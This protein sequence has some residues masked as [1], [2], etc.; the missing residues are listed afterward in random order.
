MELDK[1]I[2]IS[3]FRSD[4]RAKIYYG[5]L[6]NYF[7]PN[8]RKAY[9]RD[10]EGY[11][12]FLRENF[13]HISE[14]TAEHAHVVAYKDYLVKRVGE[15]TQNYSHVSIN[16]ALACLYAFYEYL[17]DLGKIKVNPVERVRRFKISKEVKTTDL[18]DEQVD[19]LFKVIPRESGSGKLHYAILT[20]LFNTGMRHSEASGLKFENLDYENEFLVLRYRAKGEKEMVTPLNQKTIDAVADY[21]NWCR[22]YDY[23]TNQDDFIFRPTR[24]PL[25]NDLNKQLD[26]KSMSY[27]IKKYAKKIGIKGNV[28]I[29]SARST[30]IGKLLEKG[31]SIDR[32][33][34]FVGHRDIST[35]KAYNKRKIICNDLSAKL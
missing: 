3:E 16:R 27:M 5:F 34:D 11:L 10:L 21:L 29:H 4:E 1:R 15:R 33:A 22:D 32:V 6:Q 30:V 8:T 18:S 9:K 24:N 14:F 17:W 12:I 35:T 2:K 28:T 19:A 7:S 31:I 13:R 23:S 25:N 20:L 26:S